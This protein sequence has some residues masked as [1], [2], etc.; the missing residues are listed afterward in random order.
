MADM[1]NVRSSVIISVFSATPGIG[2]TVVAIN[3]AAGFAH[4]G[5]RVCLVDLDL[6]F[7]DVAIFTIKTKY[8]NFIMELYDPHGKILYSK[9]NHLEMRVSFTT[10]ESGNYEV[11]VKHTDKKVEQIDYQLLTGIQAQDS[12]Q[13]ARES[14]IQPAEAAI[15]KLKNMTKGLIKDFNKVIKEEDKNLKVNDI[16]SGKIPMVSIITISIMVIVGLIEFIY[17]TKYLQK[18]KLI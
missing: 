18:R 17:I 3:L 16:I 11:C 10:S 12:S 7:G 6:Q 8:K 4:E 1:A 15:I 9:K 2:K 13:Y 14:S 5:Y